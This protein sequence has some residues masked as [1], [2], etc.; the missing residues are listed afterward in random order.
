M[1]DD[2]PFDRDTVER[3]Y[4]RQRREILARLDPAAG[5]S[6]AASHGDR[7]LF[8]AGFAAA[9]VVLLGTALLLRPSPAVAPIERAAGPVAPGFGELP[10][11]AYGSWPAAVEIETEADN[12][13]SVGWLFDLAEHDGLGE[14]NTESDASYTEFLAAYG[15]WE[16]AAE[17][18]VAEDAT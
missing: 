12:A 11:D 6:V 18:V 16:Q 17:E 14:T 7:R 15:A 1:R 4:E 5:A 2:P 3:F 13:A 9:A 10:F 8:L